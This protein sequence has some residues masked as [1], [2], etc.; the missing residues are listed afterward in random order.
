MKI[1]YKN[2]NKISLAT[3]PSWYAIIIALFSKCLQIDL[4][5]YKFYKTNKIYKF[6]K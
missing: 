2:G 6:L 3:N 4:Q 5:I 1:P